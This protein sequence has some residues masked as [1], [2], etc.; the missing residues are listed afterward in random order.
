MNFWGKRSTGTGTSFRSYLRTGKR[1][2]TEICWRWRKGLMLQDSIKELRRTEPRKKPER[3]QREYV[4][5]AIQKYSGSCFR[6]QRFL[7]YS[8]SEVTKWREGSSVVKVEISVHLGPDRRGSD[9]WSDTPLGS[10]PSLHLIRS[11]E[12]LPDVLWEAIGMAVSIPGKNWYAE[13][14]KAQKEVETQ[15]REWNWE[16]APWMW[17]YTD[18]IRSLKLW[19]GWNLFAMVRMNG[20]S[21]QVASAIP[22]Y[23]DRWCA[24]GETCWLSTTL[25]NPLISEVGGLHI[26]IGVDLCKKYKESP[27]SL[28]IIAASHHGDV[29]PDP[30][31]L[32]CMVAA[33]AISPARP[34]AK[35]RYTET[36][37]NR[38]KQLPRTLTNKFKGV[39]KIFAI[40][41]GREIR[42]WSYRIM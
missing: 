28:S 6:R 24:Y 15:I 17:V 20:I 7:W 10:S 22:V 40:Q 33:D 18:S 16:T 42:L 23:R 36:Y 41:A 34:G 19:T 8:S 1:R 26:Q 29:E 32:Y 3:K 12:R 5:N 2:I 21:H 30:Y 37:T 11:E 39:E 25:V 31:R 14:V 38:L 35:T 27:G 9:H 13:M 4:V